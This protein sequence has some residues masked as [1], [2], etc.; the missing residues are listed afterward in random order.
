MISLK[1]IADFERLLKKWLPFIIYKHSNQCVVSAG[2]CKN[3]ELAFTNLK[4]WNTIIFK[5]DVIEQRHISNHIAEYAN[6][7][8]ES[9]QLLLFEKSEWW[10]FVATEHV[11][12][13]LISS[14]Y[15]QWIINRALWK[16]NN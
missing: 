4:E 7:R 9:P 16:K 1:N 15:V 5:V 3:V 10:W 2:A 6:V 12:H 8:H 11:S 13:G 14:A